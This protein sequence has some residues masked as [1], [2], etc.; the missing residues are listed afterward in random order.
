MRHRAALTLALSALFAPTSVLTRRAIA[1]SELGL[2]SGAA[3]A[4]PSAPLA[5]GV[6]QTGQYRPPEGNFEPE[7]YR[8][9]ALVALALSHASTA[10]EAELALHGLA[11]ARQQHPP[12]YLLL[13]RVAT[14]QAATDLSHVTRFWWS[15]VTT[16]APDRLSRALVTLY[17]EYIHVGTRAGNQRPDVRE[18]IRLPGTHWY[19]ADGAWLGVYGG[20]FDEWFPTPE[21]LEDIGD[22][23]DFDRTYLALPP[24]TGNNLHTVLDELNAYTRDAELQMALYSVLPHGPSRARY[25]ILRQLYHLELYLARLRRR[26]PA[27][28]NRLVGYRDLTYLIK[29]LWDRAWDRVRE[30][31]GYP[32]LATDSSRA[33]QDTLANADAAIALFSAARLETPASLDPNWPA[34]H[35]RG[36]RVLLYR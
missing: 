10:A 32:L 13:T 33:E 15:Q 25:S 2:E 36:V 16:A 28:W 17:H 31:D 35:E 7:P 1:Q 5:V 11:L 9:E 26:Y 20:G 6:E 27:Q 18:P 30:L 8:E 22:P 19:A 24:D 3:P 21:L 34:L 4:A 12:A 29:G 23:Q 14:S